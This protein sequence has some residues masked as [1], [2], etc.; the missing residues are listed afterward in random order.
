MCSAGV[1]GNSQHRLL[2]NTKSESSSA[3][4]STVRHTRDSVDAEMNARRF[5]GAIRG[6]MGGGTVAGE[7]PRRLLE[8]RY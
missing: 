4:G 3:A 7:Q 8:A 5:R 2:P 6:A 1:A